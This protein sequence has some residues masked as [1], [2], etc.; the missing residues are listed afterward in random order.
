MKTANKVRFLLISIMIAGLVGCTTQSA[1]EQPLAPTMGFPTATLPVALGETESTQT[2]IEN[3]PTSAPTTTTAPKTCG[4]IGS[5]TV[6]L[7]GADKLGSSQPN[8]A[9]AI[10]VIKSDFDSQ[11]VT[12]VT[13]PRD[14]LV[15]SG[16]SNNATQVQQK[17]GLTFYDGFTA[18][19]GTALEK[20]AVAAGV[21][22]QLLQSN[23]GVHSQYY[24]T[25]QMDQF[26]SMVDTIGGV[27]LTIPIAITTDHNVSFPAGTQTLTGA[28]ALEY[29]ST[30]NPGGE[31][32]RISRQNELLIA[33]QKKLFSLETLSQVP[34]LLSQIQNSLITDLSLEQLT[35]LS[36]LAVTMPKEN[37]VFGA[38]T[39]PDLMTD[40]VPNIEKIKIYLSSLLGE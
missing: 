35:S 10:R 23:F 7:I 39:A 19:S 11:R 24:L 34:T 9:D 8:G 22:A 27:E 30:L 38:I 29:V 37:L 36:C 2:P 14:L 17:L 5:I 15:A 3:T 33:L 28:Q 13:F 16:S 20:N 32:A 26:A 31:V 21:L 12:I 40:N 4:Q 18:A 1:F 25:L 6:L